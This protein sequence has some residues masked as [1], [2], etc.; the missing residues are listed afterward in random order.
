MKRKNNGSR[1]LYI[2]YSISISSSPL[3]QPGALLRGREKKDKGDEKEK[4]DE[5][6]R[7]PN[8]DDRL[9]F[10]EG[11]SQRLVNGWRAMF[12]HRLVVVLSGAVIQLP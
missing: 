3:L 12:N 1:Q 8:D 6:N 9:Q 2:Y 10:C 11:V 5:M 4:A 7:I